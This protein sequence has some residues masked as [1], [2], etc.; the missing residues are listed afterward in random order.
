MDIIGVTVYGVKSGEA[1]GG[2][3]L[4]TQDWRELESKGDFGYSMWIGIAAICV[5]F[6]V[7]II[8]VGLVKV[9]KISP[10]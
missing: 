7:T 6:I 3:P 1:L 2:V 5:L 9:S 4:S 8:G 10:L